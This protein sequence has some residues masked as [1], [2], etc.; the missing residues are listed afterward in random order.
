MDELRSVF[1]VISLLTFI[2]I[3]A[4]AWSPAFQKRGKLAVADLMS[5]DDRNR[6]AGINVESHR[7]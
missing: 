2:A 1:T 7:G 6:V 3:I 4:W 5:D